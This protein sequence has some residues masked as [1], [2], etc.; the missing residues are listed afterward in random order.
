VTATEVFPTGVI[1]VIY[2]PTDAPAK[3][4]YDEVKDRVPE[5]R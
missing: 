5:A 2:V 1:R 3:V 4:G